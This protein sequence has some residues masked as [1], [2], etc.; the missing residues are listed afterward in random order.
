M[1]SKLCGSSHG[2]SGYERVQAAD[3]ACGSVVF[4]FVL[5]VLNSIVH[6]CVRIGYTPWSLV[7]FAES[8][9]MRLVQLS[10]AESAAPGE[11]TAADVAACDA[12]PPPRALVSTPGR[13]YSGQHTRPPADVDVPLRSR[14]DQHLATLPTPSEMRHSR[15]V[16]RRPAL[17]SA[18]GPSQDTTTQHSEPQHHQHHHDAPYAGPSAL[19]PELH[20]QQES[21]YADHGYQNGVQGNGVSTAGLGLL[22]S[23]HADVHSV[24]GQGQ[25]QGAAVSSTNGV[26][27]DDGRLRLLDRPTRL[28]STQGMEDELPGAQHVLGRA[29]SP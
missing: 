20:T 14:A 2:M 9:G 4:S 5:Q 18:A 10:V 7:D 15:S 16:S 19:Q 27:P 24:P 29:R 28:V 13:A 3:F 22:H 26:V 25:G 21:E 6:S 8:K 17:F 11:D 23:A 1:H 12:E